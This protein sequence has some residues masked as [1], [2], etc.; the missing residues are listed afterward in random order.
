[1][2]PDWTYLRFLAALMYLA[3][4]DSLLLFLGTLLVVSMPE[5]KYERYLRALVA[6]V[7]LIL[8]VPYF[9]LSVTGIDWE[10]KAYC[11]FDAVPFVVGGLTVGLVTVYGFSSKP[12]VTR[13]GPRS[14]FYSACFEMLRYTFVMGLFHS[15]ILFNGFG[16][17][18]LP[19]VVSCSVPWSIEPVGKWKNLPKPALEITTAL[20]VYTYLTIFYVVFEWLMYR[21]FTRKIYTALGNQFQGD[22]KVFAHWLRS[23]LVSIALFLPSRYAFVSQYSQVRDFESDSYGYILT[24]LTVLASMATIHVVY[25]L[26]ETIGNDLS[27]RNNNMSEPT[28]G[29]L[30][31]ISKSETLPAYQLLKQ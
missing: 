15:F 9:L 7:A 22:R 27:T 5:C 28:S 6:V 4:L 20:P 17:S 24:L 13:F 14:D 8:V 11:A 16:E 23:C 10:S 31:F 18:P 25:I 2:A 3:D 21:S 26:F 30:P 12:V 29:T 19:D 1:M